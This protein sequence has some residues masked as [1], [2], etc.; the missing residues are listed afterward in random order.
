MKQNGSS[1]IEL[2]V[3]IA[4]IGVLLTIATI[5]F[6]D[7]SM[8]YNIES[9]VNEM[10][11]DFANARI[12]ATSRN[13]LHFINLSSSQ[14]SVTEDSD[15]NGTREATDTLVISKILKNPIN[16]TGAAEISFDARGL[17]SLNE[18]ISVS[19]TSSASFDCISVSITRIGI[20]KMIGGSC[21]A[22]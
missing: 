15:N 12:K 6:R 11:V 9:Q 20:G 16:W 22:K 5:N 1:L 4:I 21:A 3:V 7:W 14:Y 2:L 8:R 18:T 17:A 19:N 10:Y 13:R